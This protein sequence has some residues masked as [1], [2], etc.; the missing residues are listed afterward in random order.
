ML[1][2]NFILEILLKSWKQHVINSKFFVYVCIIFAEAAYWFHIYCLVSMI[3]VAGMQNMNGTST[4]QQDL[5]V[6]LNVWAMHL[7]VSTLF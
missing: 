1:D 7:S 4:G 2:N 6:D 5:L 3:S